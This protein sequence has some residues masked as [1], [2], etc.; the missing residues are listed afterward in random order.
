MQQ[1]TGYSQGDV[2]KEKENKIPKISLGK[3]MGE[4]LHMYTC[5]LNFAI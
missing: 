2:N 4:Y 5:K 1:H 3:I